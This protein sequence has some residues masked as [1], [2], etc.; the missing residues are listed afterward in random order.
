MSKPLVDS[1]KK[2]WMGANN[3]QFNNDRN[4]GEIILQSLANRNG[5]NVMQVNYSDSIVSQISLC[6]LLRST[7]WWWYGRVV[8]KSRS[9]PP[10]YTLCTKSTENRMHARSPDCSHC[11]KP[12]QIDTT[13]IRSNLYWNTHLSIGCF[14][15]FG[16]SKKMKPEKVE[17]DHQFIFFHF[18]QT[19][20]PILFNESNPRW[21]SATQTLQP[22]FKILSLTLDSRHKYSLSTETLM[23]STVSI[24]WC[25]Q[26]A[27]KTISC[28]LIRETKSSHSLK[29]V[30]IHNY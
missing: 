30:D 27:T 5:E 6:E 24:G 23:V 9:S 21:Y 16:F 17:T 11:Q 29:E 22:R 19:E 20:N 7:D 8:N 26:R 14:P 25:I 3:H 18:H 4:V 2:I 12:S 1:F 13:D 15:R 28:K 10:N